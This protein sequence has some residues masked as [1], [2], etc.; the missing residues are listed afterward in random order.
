MTRKQIEELTDEE[1]ISL[2]KVLEEYEKFL[3]KEGE[4]N[5]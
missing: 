2:Y 5:D 3:E 1:L 4:K